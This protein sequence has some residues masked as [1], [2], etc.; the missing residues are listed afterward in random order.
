[1]WYARS[2]TYSDD[3]TR[4]RRQRCVLGAILDQADPATV[5]TRFNKIALATKELIR[6]DIPRSML[7]NL[8]PL[9]LTVKNA[10]VSSIQFV[11]PLISTG[12]PDWNKIRDIAD[13]AIHDSAATKPAVAASAGASPTPKKST[14]KSTKEPGDNPAKGLTEGCGGAL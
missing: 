11:P 10:K 7:K 14:K 2:R 5:L 3:Y 6:T 1:M 9:A 12:Y 13:K 8:V 4:M